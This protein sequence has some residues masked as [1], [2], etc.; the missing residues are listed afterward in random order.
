[1]PF[2]I[3]VH[4][5]H[6]RDIFKMYKIKSLQLKKIVQTSSIAPNEIKQINPMY[7]LKVNPTVFTI[8]VHINKT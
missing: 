5:I 2:L 8:N 7:N 6:M 1:M 4:P 3:T